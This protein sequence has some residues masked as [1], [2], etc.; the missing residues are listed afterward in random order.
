M[1][2]REVQIKTSENTAPA[3]FAGGGCDLAGLP[4]S[5]AFQV[6]ALVYIL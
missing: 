3:G 4:R 1:D 5:P 2:H 6:G